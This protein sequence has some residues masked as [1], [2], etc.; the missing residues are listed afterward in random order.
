MAVPDFQTLM[1]PVLRLAAAS[2]T[3][4]AECAT[5][6]ADE[7]H[8]SEADIAELLPSGKQT[9][10][11]NRLNWAKSYLGQAGLI[12]TTKRGYFRATQ[13]GREVLQS[14]V[15]KIDRN[16]LERFPGYL[17][18][19][20]RSGQNEEEE[21]HAPNIASQA[22]VPKTPEER[23]DAAA[24]EIE[25]QLRTQLLEQIL[26][27]SPALF[28]KTIVNLLIAMG[29]GGDRQE[30]GRRIGG[31]GD[32]GVDGVIDQDSLGLDMIYLQAKRYK[33]ENAIG[34]S[35]IR[36][37]SG[38]LLGKGASKG[39]FVTTSRFSDA[40]RRFAEA[41]R[42]QRLVLID[43][44]ELTRLMVKHNVAV[45]TERAVELKKIDLDYFDEE[46]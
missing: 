23:I 7:F 24:L 34:E 25:S 14:G 32:G 20:E 8:M 39:V 5:R 40:A 3:R 22:Q 19:K 11:K 28:E 26:D 38:A 45:R 21:P 18:F 16:F 44:E 46:E 33:P 42:Q 36:E 12:E 30:A 10:L 9:R 2:E 4:V 27:A 17:E 15:A 35:Q 37:F 6:I 41:M 43:G 13:A 31:T 29:Y 1:L